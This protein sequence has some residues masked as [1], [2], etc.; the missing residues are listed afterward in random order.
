M[1]A[2]SAPC[3]PPAPAETQSHC[4]GER[5]QGIHLWTLEEKEGES[6]KWKSWGWVCSGASILSQEG[7]GTGGTSDRGHES[8]RGPTGVSPQDLGV[9]AEIPQRRDGVR[10]G[11]HRNLLK[12][13]EG[14]RTLPHL[15]G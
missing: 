9:E 10:G 4:L 8:L 5:E 13:L 7:V 3:R 14:G 11:G 12:V 2:Q 15:Q 1:A 6:R